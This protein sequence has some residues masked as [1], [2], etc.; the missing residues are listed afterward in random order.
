MMKVFDEGKLY[1]VKE[2]TFTKYTHLLER[3]LQLLIEENR[4]LKRLLKEIYKYFED[5]YGTIDFK[6][7]KKIEKVIE[8]KLTEVEK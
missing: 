3:Q 4:E 6:L 8:N 5:G 1:K 2:D 7:L